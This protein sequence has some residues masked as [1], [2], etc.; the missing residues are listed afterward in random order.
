MK[1]TRPE[2]IGGLVD[3]LETKRYDLELLGAVFKGILKEL[4]EEEK[5][6]QDTLFN[7]FTKDQIRG[8][9][10]TRVKAEIKPKNHYSLS[11]KKTLASFVMATGAWDIFTSH[12]NSRAIKDRLKA[13]IEMTEMGVRVWESIEIVLKPI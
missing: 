10:G 12:L 5:E 8:A 7:S 4:E 9:L 6:I 2:S 1:E 13:G 3:A 11:N